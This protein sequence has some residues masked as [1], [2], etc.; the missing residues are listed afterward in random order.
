MCSD[1]CSEPAALRPK[2]RPANVPSSAVWAGGADGGAYLRCV[3]DSQ[4]NVDRC[5]IWNDFTGE[6]VA[7]GDY[8]LAKEHRAATYTEL[9][10]SGAVNDFIYLSDGRVLVRVASK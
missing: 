9:K 4:R 8:Q 7:S 5:E 6:L 10:F 3:V 2:Q 1:G